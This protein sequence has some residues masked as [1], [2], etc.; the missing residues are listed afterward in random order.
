MAQQL[1]RDDW[2]GVFEEGFGESTPK[3]AQ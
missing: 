3:L 1:E 2:I